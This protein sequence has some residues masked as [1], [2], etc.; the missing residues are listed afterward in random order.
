MCLTTIVTELFNFLS[1]KYELDWFGIFLPVTTH[2]H[3]V[4][5][6]F[7]VYRNWGGNTGTKHSFI[8]ELRFC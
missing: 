6:L 5:A 8:F 4:Q 7:D 3:Y 1:T 2:A